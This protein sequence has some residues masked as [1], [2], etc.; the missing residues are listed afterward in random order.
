M[1]NADR[2]A[3]FVR[4]A[5]RMPHPYAWVASVT[6]G[7]PASLVFA[8]SRSSWWLTATALF[9]AVIWWDHYC[10]KRCVRAWPGR[11]SDR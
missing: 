8:R 10:T 9:V 11:R 7:L 3:E 4:W 2:A 5:D 1:R 6:F